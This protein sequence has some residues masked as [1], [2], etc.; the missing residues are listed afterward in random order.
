M[1][2]ADIHLA[3]DLS[4]SASFAVLIVAAGRGSRAGNGLPKQYRPLAGR[5]MLAHTIQAIVEALPKTPVRCVIHPDD[6]DLYH[7]VLAHLDETERTHLEPPAYGGNTRQISVK[8]GLTALAAAEKTP[9]IVLI[10]DAARPF[11]STSLIRASIKAALTH[12]AA[13]PGVPVTDTIKQV[14]VRDEV[15]A[16]PDRSS[17]RAV[18]TPQAFAFDLIFKA[19]N[20]AAV[21]GISDLTD[22][23]ALAEWAGYTVAIFPGETGN[24]KVTSA[25]DFSAAET[26]LLK[27]LPDIRIGQGYDVHALGEGCGVWLGGVNIPHNQSLIGHSDADVLSHAMTDALLGAMADGDI[28]SHFPPSDPQWKG[29]ASRIFLKTAADRLRSRGGM[30][31]NIDATIICERPKIGPH[32]ES[33]RLSIS[34]ILGI[35]LDRVAIKATTTERLGFTGREEGIAVMAI[36]TIRLPLE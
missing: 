17:L 3:A 16:T 32:R 15:I 10:Q 7:Q 25:A 26:R 22:D 19:H 2:L 21:A 5:P 20:M 6:Q 35:S 33:I 28:G 31:A 27:D 12:G 4:D 8:N 14:N 30:I 11:S 18:Q 24:M 1:P 36:A 23:G 29:A 9:K 34:E 13:I